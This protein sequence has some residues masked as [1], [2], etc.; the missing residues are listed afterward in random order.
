MGRGEE[1]FWN[2]YFHLLYDF[3]VCFFVIRMY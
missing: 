3:A 2:E 1:G